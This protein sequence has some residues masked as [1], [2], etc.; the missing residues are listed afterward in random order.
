MKK[1]AAFLLFMPLIMIIVSGCLPAIII[2]GAV[3]AVG[4]YA[5]SKDAIQGETDK[6]YDVL[7]N[8]AGTIA[9]IRGKVKVE[10]AVKGRI[11]LEAESSRV[12]ITLDRLTQST[13]RVRVKAR[14]YHLPNMALAQDI[15]V[16][17]MEGIH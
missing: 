13:T 8:S 5:V 10:D 11:E 6:S 7:W 17:I 12:Y 1:R 14:K 16:K 3:G 15:F 2:G 4:G 9:R